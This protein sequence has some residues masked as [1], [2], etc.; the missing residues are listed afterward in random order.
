MTH[1]TAKFMCGIMVYDTYIPSEGVLCLYSNQIRTVAVC[2][3]L[4][5]TVVYQDVHV[6]TV[7]CT[8]ST[9]TLVSVGL[10]P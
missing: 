9:K 8:V 1:V 5:C 10:R 7:C 3:I 6:R 2:T 4:Y